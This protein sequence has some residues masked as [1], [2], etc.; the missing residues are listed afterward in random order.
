[1]GHLPAGG[2]GG[3]GPSGTRLGV[4]ELYQRQQR[5]KPGKIK[6]LSIMNLM[7]VWR[8]DYLDFASR[9]LGRMGRGDPNGR[10]CSR[11]PAF[12]TRS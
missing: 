5:P 1:M 2:G 12:S 6:E 11:V 9:R 3:H 7:W 10:L 8:R 4:R